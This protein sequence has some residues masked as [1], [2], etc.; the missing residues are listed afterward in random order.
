[1]INAYK[2]LIEQPERKLRPLE[3]RRRWVNIIKMDHN[4]VGSWDFDCILL[5]LDGVQWHALVNTL[6]TYL[7]GLCHIECVSSDAGN[8]KYIQNL[9]W[10][11]S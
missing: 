8:N 3:S 10:N 1:M 6:T 4:N 11:T 9:V 7:E 5:H 2:I